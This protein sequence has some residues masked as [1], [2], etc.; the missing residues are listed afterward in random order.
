MDRISSTLQSTIAMA[1]VDEDATITNRA[2]KDGIFMFNERIRLVVTG[3]S[4]SIILCGR[5]HR[6]GHASDSTACPLPS[7]AVRC[8]RCGG[9]H[10][11]LD[12]ATFCPNPHDKAGECACLFP[13]LNCGG[14]HNA[15][16]PFCKLK[17][18]FAPAPLAP[19]PALSPLAQPTSSAKDKGKA[20]A[21][22]PVDPSTPSQGT[23]ASTSAGG[24][25]TTVV[26]KGKNMVPA[27][28]G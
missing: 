3:D 26:R 4:P 14:N 16:S 11:S 1:Y 5:C 8:V 9:S 28:I 19:R 17:K 12:H 23:E 2:S 20:A 18:G 22:P 6:I 21:P 10:H 27:P 24:D 25:F 13:C 7:N 15:R